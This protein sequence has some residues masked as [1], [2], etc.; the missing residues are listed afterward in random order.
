MISNEVNC[1]AVILFELI[2]IGRMCD[3]VLGWGAVPLDKYKRG[4]VALLKGPL[5]LRFT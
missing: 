5:D 3:D 4:K 1:S 2:E